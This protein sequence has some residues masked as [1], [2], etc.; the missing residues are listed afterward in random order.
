[1][2]HHHAGQK[3][4]KHP[5]SFNDLAAEWDS[6][7]RLERAQA[8]A[9]LMQPWVPHN[10]RTVLDVGCGTGLVG[11]ALAHRIHETTNA[12]E[13]NVANPLQLAGV[14]PSEGMR[15]KARER[16]LMT[17]PSLDDAENTLGAASV[18]VV[19]S[20][21]AMHHMADV[22]HVLQQ[23][24]LLLKPGGVL[25]IADLDEGQ[26]FFHAHAHAREA[27]HA[28]DRD[29]VHHHGFSREQ[30]ASWCVQAG[31]ADVD[32]SDGYSGVRTGDDGQEHPYTLFFARGVKN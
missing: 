20:S 3:H 6:P 31:F 2:T 18:D 13:G 5:E 29:G 27:T 15:D 32:V 9:A 12:A 26:E 16:G 14:D 23:C 7:T 17:F 28:H 10:A 1:M 11:S 21:M 19:L 4:D 8:L 30:F 22:S 25:L 24:A